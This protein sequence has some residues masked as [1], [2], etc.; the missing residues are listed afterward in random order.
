MCACA[1]YGRSRTLLTP[2]TVSSIRRSPSQISSGLRTTVASGVRCEASVK[3]DRGDNGGE[4]ISHA[5]AVLFAAYGIQR[6]TL[7]TPA[8]RD[9]GDIVGFSW[10]REFDGRHPLQ[11]RLTHSG[12]PFALYPP[13]R[14]AAEHLRVVGCAAY[15]LVPAGS[16]LRSERYLPNARPSMQLDIDPFSPDTGLCATSD[17]RLANVAR[18]WRRHDSQGVHECALRS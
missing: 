7:R 6:G 5:C 11:H 18:V 2:S 14:P 9:C 15:R 8:Q 17:E 1:L 16:R 10:G 3:H 4:F 12:R 13:L